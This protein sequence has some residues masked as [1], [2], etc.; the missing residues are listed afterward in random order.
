MEDQWLERSNSHHRES[1]VSEMT[2]ANSSSGRWNYEREIAENFAESGDS[3]VRTASGFRVHKGM[4]ELF[5]NV[6]LLVQIN[7]DLLTN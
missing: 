1:P 2:Q 4:N 7:K 5:I 3:S 6:M